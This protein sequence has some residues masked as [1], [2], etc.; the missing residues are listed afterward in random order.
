MQTRQLHLIREVAELLEGGDVR[1][2]LSGGWAVDF[3]AGRITR[4]HSDVDIVVYHED[5]PRLVALLAEAG[6]DP[7]GEGPGIAWFER[8]GL[9]LETTFIRESG[10]DLV[11]PGYESWPWP[12]EGWVCT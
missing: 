8:D 1:F 3:H 11:T 7:V 10:E 6:L 2:W 9:R 4:G 12:E 5:Q